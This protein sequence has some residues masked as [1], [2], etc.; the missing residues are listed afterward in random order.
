[1]SASSGQQQPPLS[2]AWDAV[3]RNTE[4]EYDNDRQEQLCTLP[5]RRDELLPVRPR[6]NEVNNERFAWL[7]RDTILPSTEWL[8]SQQVD[9]RT[10]Y[11]ETLHAWIKS[12]AAHMW[13]YFCRRL[14]Q[15]GYITV[16]ARGSSNSN[17][18]RGFKCD[19]CNEHD[20]AEAAYARQSFS[21]KSFSFK[22]LAM[23][24]R[25]EF[26]VA[27]LESGRS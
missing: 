21:F 12:I 27:T 9:R 4:I 23:T 6:R 3:V 7:H 16:R 13:C 17:E 14:H 26:C 15:A 22:V 5:R 18:P 25:N 8:M 20:A 11:E 19:K 2:C 24:R 10:T 1:M